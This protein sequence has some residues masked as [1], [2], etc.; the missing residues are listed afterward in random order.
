[1]GNKYE[2][3]EGDCLKLIAKRLGISIAELQAMN[4]DQIKNV[5]LIYAGNLLNIPANDD[6]SQDNQAKSEPAYP[7]DIKPTEVSAERI[8][9]PELPKAPGSVCEPKEYV[10]VVFYPSMP[11]TGKQGWFALTQ[12]AKDKLEEEIAHMRS[13]MRSLAAGD[14][15]DAMLELSKYGILSKF[16]SCDHERFLVDS[17]DKKR[18]RAL[19]LL[20]LAL[21][22]EVLRVPEVLLEQAMQD[23]EVSQEFLS[24]YSDAYADQLFWEE[25]QNLLNVGFKTALKRSVL[26]IFSEGPSSEDYII[27]YREVRTD[28]IADVMEQLADEIETLEKKARKEAAKKLT[29]DGTPFT[30]SDSMGYFTSKQQNTVHAALNN[31]HKA[32]GMYSLELEDICEDKPESIQRRLEL[33]QQDSKVAAQLTPYEFKARFAGRFVP[34]FTLN[35]NLMV[36]I[37]QCLT[38]DELIKVQPESFKYY[39]KLDEAAE[40]K[41]IAE[42]FARIPGLKDMT[43]VPGEALSWSYYPCIAVLHKLEASLKTKLAELKDI[44][45]VGKL[46]KEVLGD[47]VQCKKALL[48]RVEHFEKT[49]KAHAAAKTY[50]RLFTSADKVYTPV[51]KEKAWKPAKKTGSLYTKA[52]KADLTVVECYLS[53]EGGKTAFVRGPSWLV[54]DDTASRVECGDHLF[55]LKPGFKSAEPMQPAAKKNL[56]PGGEPIPEPEPESQEGSSPEGVLEK[57]TQAYFA[58]LA[59]KFPVKANFKNTLVSFDKAFLKKEIYRWESEGPKINETAYHISAECQFLRFSSAVS[60]GDD[61]D[62][63]KLTDAIQNQNV[64]FGLVDAKATLNLA[65]GQSTLTVEYPSEAGYVFTIPYIAYVPSE[66][67]KIK[68]EVLYKA[69]RK[70][71]SRFFDAGKLKL[72][73]AFTLYG[74]VGASVNLGASVE[75]GNLDEGGVGVKGFTESYQGYNAYQ[76]EAAQ[77]SN[78]DG[79]L[80]AQSKAADI[81]A[82]AGVFAGVEAGGEFVGSLKWKAPERVAGQ[83]AEKGGDKNGFVS[84]GQFTAKAAVAYAAAASGV[85]K[86]TVSGGKIIFIMAARLALGPGVSGKWG[87]EISPLV[88]NSFID[89]IL[90]IMDKEGFR[91]L[92]LFDESIDP[93]S[94]ENSFELFNMFLTAVMVTGLKAADVLLLPFEQIKAFNDESTREK[95]A[96]VLADFI[97][98][99]AETALPWVKKMPPETL[100]RLL[101]T[102]TDKQTYSWTEKGQDIF[103]GG[104]S[105]EDRDTANDSKQ[106]DAM[107]QVL[108]WLVDGNVLNDQ[109]TFFSPSEIQR[110]HFEETLSRMSSKGQKPDVYKEEWQMLLVS[111]RRIIYLYES[112]ARSENGKG[113]SPSAISNMIYRFRQLLLA[114][115][116]DYIFYMDKGYISDDYAAIYIGDCQNDGAEQKA[117]QQA[118]G[119]N[120]NY[121]LISVMDIE[122][123]A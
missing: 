105:R 116:D 30:Y 37:E 123:Q 39:E 9:L 58:K 22:L 51:F 63:S 29:D 65:Q 32:R 52:G 57:R 56:I 98:K 91:R 62:V 3:I 61:L 104:S 46:P 35:T 67:L 48:A 89:H 42:V 53:S 80:I 94:G 12:Q 14:V 50:Q 16:Q 112:S 76:H 87:F 27:N 108:L 95:L 40:K 85:I 31:V 7:D 78:A 38:D 73:G 5:D 101:Y 2:I 8:Q 84:F 114:L 100:G 118:V 110:R 10:D 72:Q 20:Q 90:T 122:G 69:A 28:A 119:I 113:K 59:K 96:P 92:N 75:F 17:D 71:H 109:I 4:S 82:T 45:G 111:I 79:D 97:N 77:I 24:R 60:V 55:D 68:Q 120:S 11:K 74:M 83:V 93:E 117:R 25:C 19:L 54:P 103:S 1:M 15:N 41:L 66:P 49:A 23:R 44:L 106:R 21:K 34:I 70:K 99:D 115:S 81:T 121:Q 33:W 6:K 36:L 43:T 47:L 26:G 102:L 64:K 86:L 88:I 18:Y 107:Q 13:V